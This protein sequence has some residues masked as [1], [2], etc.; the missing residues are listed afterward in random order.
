M[1]ATVQIFVP[2]YKLKQV[3]CLTATN[4]D[5]NY[6]APHGLVLPATVYTG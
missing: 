2:E 4:E 6:Y 1:Y 3:I 5:A